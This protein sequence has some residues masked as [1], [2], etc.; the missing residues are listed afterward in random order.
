ML[1][2]TLLAGADSLTA[3]KWL[4]D[5]IYFEQGNMSSLDGNF[6]LATMQLVSKDSLGSTTIELNHLGNRKSAFYR[7][8]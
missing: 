3:G 7:C 1:R 2:D 8:R 6:A 4:M 5:L